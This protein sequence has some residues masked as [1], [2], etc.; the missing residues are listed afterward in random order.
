M[1]LVI[2]GFVLFSL[3]V[4]N[5]DRVITS[6]EE[7]TNHSEYLAVATEVGQ[8]LLSKISSK[9]FDQNTVSNPVFSP[10]LL[11]PA[12]SLGY[13]TGETPATFNDVDDYNNYTENDTTPRAGVFH[14]R[15]IVNY[16]DSTNS[17]IVLTSSV[18]R[19][20][21]IQVDITSDF[22]K[23]TVKLYYYKSY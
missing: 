8:N 12:A 22:M 13:E 14:L 6:S 21:R 20:K 7:Q 1:I 2:G 9:A 19:I 16:V 17:N 11:T 18:S 3:L 4:I 23:D 15:S 5:I 10:S